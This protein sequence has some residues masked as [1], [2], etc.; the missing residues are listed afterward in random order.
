MTGKLDH[1]GALSVSFA[2]ACLGVWATWLQY[3]AL[4]LRFRLPEWVLPHER[5]LAVCELLYLLGGMLVTVYR[6]GLFSRQAGS[7]AGDPG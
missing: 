2:A 7:R 6:T 5:A 1:L 4:G 3:L